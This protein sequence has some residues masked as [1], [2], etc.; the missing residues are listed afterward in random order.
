[1]K[2]RG[3][4]VARREVS[5]APTSNVSTHSRTGNFPATDLQITLNGR[6]NY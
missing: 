3:L 2:K 4:Y 6:K 5:R 1:M